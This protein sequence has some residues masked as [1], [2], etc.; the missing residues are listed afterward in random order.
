MYQNPKNQNNTQ[1]ST[2]VTQEINAEKNG[3]PSQVGNEMLNQLIDQGS[4]GNNGGTGNLPNSAKKALINAAENVIEEKPKKNKP[5]FYQD[6]ENDIRNQEF[7]F[8]VD[9]DMAAELDPNESQE[10]S[11][12]ERRS[13]K[14]GDL[15]EAEKDQYPVKDWNFTPQ[16]MKD[17]KG[18]NWWTKFKNRTASFFGSIFSAIGTSFFGIKPIVGAAKRNAANK[19]KRALEANS[20]IQKKKDHTA[21]PGWEGAK[22][23]PNANSGE[24]I[25][26]DFRRVPTVWS[27]IIGE[28]ASE[29][30]NDEE[31]PLPPKITIYVEQPKDNSKESMAGREMGHTMIGIEYSRFSHLSNKYER[32]KLQYGFYPVTSVS[33][34]GNSELA[35][36][37]DAIIPG[38]L[39]ND[40]GHSYTVSR[41]YPATAKQVNAILQASETYADGGYG[42]FARNCTTFVRD[43]AKIAHLP[44][45]DKL[46]QLEEVGFST[47]A[48]LARIASDAAGENSVSG[49]EEG[50]VKNS[51]REDLS[52]ANYGNNRVTEE[53][54]DTLKWSTKGGPSEIKETY[55]PASVGQKLRT[56]TTGQIGSYYYKGDI[57]DSDEYNL[58]EIQREIDKQGVALK[59]IFVKQMLPEATHTNKKIP[60][61]LN[62]AINSITIMG[63]S[64]N[65]VKIKHKK[66]TV[67]DISEIQRARNYMSKDIALLNTLYFQY[68]KGDKRLHEPVMKMISLLNNGIRLLDNDYVQA[69]NAYVEDSDLGA[70]SKELYHDKNIKIGD[71]TVNISPTL[72]EAYLQIYKTPER[73]IEEYSKYEKLK[74]SNKEGS[75]SFREKKDWGRAE[76]MHTLAK[77]FVKAHRYMLDKDNYNQQDIDYAFMEH[78]RER[79]NG[80][81]GEKVS[82][83]LLP[84]S[85][86]ET[87]ISLILGKIFGGM[88]ERYKTEMG[89]KPE[90]ESLANNGKP[91]SDWLDKDLSDSLLKNRDKMI[92]VIRGMKKSMKPSKQEDGKN[93][94]VK[95]NDLFSNLYE[96]IYF[97]WVGKLF[98]NNDER[99]D[100]ELNDIMY[101]QQ[102]YSTMPAN[103]KTKF[104]KL[105]KVLIKQVLL[106]EKTADD[107]LVQIWNKKNSQPL[108][109]K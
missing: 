3:L 83:D 49:M 56:E 104:P 86:G 61:E 53:D 93:T 14:K 94:E 68:F 32:Y 2:R 12:S 78:K 55:I 97:S 88:R 4:A 23:D 17:V 37:N 81:N 25:L 95:E 21:I 92:Q 1:A 69:Y 60:S 41:T 7:E 102:S 5:L 63:G 106:E 31:K 99:K 72:Y 105:L 76:R 29:V 57:E 43:M 58:E 38:Q 26:A 13:G 80:K 36:M 44:V 11:Y 96:T 24:D 54:F 18:P 73:A 42:Y 20:K 74:Q 50:M 45:S 16:K 59:E 19:K 70:V 85:T 108:Q 40:A 109:E 87:Y 67:P 62:R 30:V 39:M 52:Y 103:S 47:L 35:M 101:I 75:L 84:S 51:Q 91:I 22:Y 77:E 79:E 107:S 98:K 82:G 48:N 8:D 28:R 9:D 71:K 10:V 64:L 90:N 65:I 15:K 89:S 100:I 34:G 66:N 33:K 27:E 46:F 6:A